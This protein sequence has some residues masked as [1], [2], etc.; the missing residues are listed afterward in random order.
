MNPHRSELFFAK[1]TVFVEGESDRIVLEMMGKHLE[2]YDSEI[3]IVETGGKDN[4]PYY[5]QLAEAFELDYVIM[6]DEDARDEDIGEAPVKEIDECEECFKRKSAQFKSL[7]DHP[8]KNKKIRELITKGQL[9]LWYKT[10]NKKFDIPAG[11]SKGASAQQWC[12]KVQ[13][14]VIDMPQELRD[15]VQKIYSLEALQE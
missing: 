4:L 1:R 2:V 8:K 10:L 13:N 12:E 14:G 3:T 6:H 7:K 5:I 15:V 11:K 9:I